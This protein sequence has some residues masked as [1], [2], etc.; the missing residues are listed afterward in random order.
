MI[1]E[2]DEKLVEVLRRRVKGVRISFQPGGKPPYVQVRRGV[3]RFRPESQVV[4]EQISED[5][6][7]EFKV[8][9]PV[10]RIELRVAPMPPSAE[11]SVKGR[12][13]D[14]ETYAVRGASI[15][16]SKPIEGEV[17]VRY[18][19]VTGIRLTR[20]TTITL[21]YYIE[22]VAT[23]IGE[24]DGLLEKVLAAL[25]LEE[26]ENMRIDVLKM[27]VVRGEDGVW[28]G[29]LKIRISSEWT[30]ESVDRSII[31]GISVATRRN[32]G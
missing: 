2:I 28:K 23:S 11:V 21:V 30:A 6:R 10:R 31:K 16:L 4:E 19:G 24:L 7:E 29:V 17:E 27:K 8:D 1:I 5:L 20:K 22:I 26:I 32:V 13:I 12:R 15:T 14:P 25:L 18:R 3:V 9:E